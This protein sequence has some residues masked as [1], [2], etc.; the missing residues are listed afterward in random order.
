M[1]GPGEAS[2]AQLRVCER[3]ELQ[4]IPPEEMVALAMSTLGQ[5]PVHGA[6]V[7]RPE[8]GTISWFFHCGE[9]SD[10]ADFYQPVH[11]THLQTMLPLVLRYLQLPPGTR[12]IIDDK[13]FEDVW[14]ESS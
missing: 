2:K 6:R 5:M 4:P 3:H 13:G 1:N 14:S 11:A 9:F 12:F 10:A 8:N 7:E